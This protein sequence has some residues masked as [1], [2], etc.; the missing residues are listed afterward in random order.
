MRYLIAVC[1]SVLGFCIGGLFAGCGSG[2]GDVNAATDANGNPLPTHEETTYLCEH[3]GDIYSCQN[4]GACAT[5]TMIAYALSS[6]QDPVTGKSY[7]AYKLTSGE[8]TIIAECGA[9][10]VYSPS[11]TTNTTINTTT[12]TTADTTTTDSHN[13]TPEATPT[14]TS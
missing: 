13:T 4:G 8:I 9:T 10:V 1:V 12:D 5:S 2:G 6:G 7:V 3:D 14:P 11:E